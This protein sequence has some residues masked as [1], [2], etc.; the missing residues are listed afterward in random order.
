MLYEN[1]SISVY[2]YNNDE[3]INNVMHQPIHEADFI[4]D[5]HE[6]EPST[7]IHKKKVSKYYIVFFLI[8]SVILLYFLIVK[9]C[10]GMI[11]NTPNNI[12]RIMYSE[13]IFN[14]RH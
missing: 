9:S 7:K 3:N 13:P 14:L 1:D 4:N 12:N 6:M 2:D 5:S 10:N 11:F 8:A